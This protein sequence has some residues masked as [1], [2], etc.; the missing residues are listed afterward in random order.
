[1]PYTP[2]SGDSTGGNGSGN[3]SG[4]AAGGF[5]FE[6]GMAG[7]AGMGNAPEPE[8][9]AS[10]TVVGERLPLDVFVLLDQSGSMTE[11]EDRWGPV[12]AA[13]LGF[14]DDPTSQGVG[15]ALQYFPLGA[16]KREDPIICQAD[17]YK[18]PSVAF[19]QLPQAAGAIRTSIE[20]HKFGAAEADTPAHWGTPTGPAVQG[21]LTYLRTW[22]AEHA[23]HRTVLLLA[24][25]G[26]PSRLCAKN[27]I[28][29]IAA[30]IAEAAAAPAPISTYVIG[31]GKIES[32]NELA[33]AG[34]TGKAA[35]VVSGSGGEA[36]RKEFLA[37]LQAIRNA[38]V[39]CAVRIPE[40]MG[41]VDLG[42]VNVEITGAGGNKQ[43]VPRV[44][45]AAACKAGMPAWHFD[46]ADKPNSLVMCPS[47]CEQ[48]SAPGARIDVVIGC[49]TVVVL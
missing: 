13:I 25:D 38:A 33:E 21:V 3:G 44:E 6:P 17:N 41:T 15:V 30:L 16:Q 49:K 12:T 37:A 29:D 26:Q 7:Q 32:L 34:D 5:S 18:T 19:A 48:V 24:T 2:G 42:K 47:A 35:F 45:G 23:D 11:G 4:G 28:K 27:T 43:V 10:Q 39:P 20:A 14:V 36:I 22:Q 1:M 46:A 31:I 40:A 9:C 8:A